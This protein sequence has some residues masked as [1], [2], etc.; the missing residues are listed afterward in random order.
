MELRDE[1]L[2]VKK[3]TRVPN[4]TFFINEVLLAKT[5]FNCP[6]TRFG[7][8]FNFRGKK[9]SALQYQQAVNLT[10]EDASQNSCSPWFF[11][12]RKRFFARFCQQ[13]F[14]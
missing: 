8:I 2:N 7:L 13:L 10:L 14:L 9:I 4:D 6:Q 5:L 12:A 3:T 11:P 1:E